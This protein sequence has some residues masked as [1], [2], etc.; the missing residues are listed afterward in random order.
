[1]KILPAN[2]TVFKQNPV[3]TLRQVTE[4]ADVTNLQLPLFPLGQSRNHAIK[5]VE[6]SLILSLERQ[7][8]LLQQILV[9]LGSPNRTLRV[10][11]HVNVL[12]ESTGIVVLESS[13][14][15]ESFQNRVRFQNLLF[16][17]AVLVAEG[18]KKLQDEFGRFSLTR[19]RFSGYYYTL[20][21]NEE[22]NRIFIIVQE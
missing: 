14:I 12:S 22:E 1:M 19:S 16:N 18:R 13:R 21:L 17:P 6:V 2:F 15:S 7:S 20:V 4:F 11:M 3:A 10:E 5:Y 8:R 9:N